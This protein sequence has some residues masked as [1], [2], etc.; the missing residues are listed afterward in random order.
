MS[1]TLPVSEIQRRMMEK[2]HKISL[3]DDPGRYLCNQVFYKALALLATPRFSCRAGF[4]HLP[5]SA[6]YSTERS[7]EA[8]VEVI[9]LLANLHWESE[10]G[11]LVS[12]RDR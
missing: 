3:S 8:L 6:H 9:D 7:V 1:A 11:L 10:A 2:G 12:R 4:I 5:L